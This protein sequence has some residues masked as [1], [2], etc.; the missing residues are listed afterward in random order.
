MHANL[1]QGIQRTLDKALAEYSGTFKHIP[2]TA[3]SRRKY[4]ILLFMHNAIAA[5]A[6][7]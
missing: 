3:A 6:E 7:I 2:E 1:R 5:P 4:L